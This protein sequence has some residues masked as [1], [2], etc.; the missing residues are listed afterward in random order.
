MEKKTKTLC[1]RD[2]ILIVEIVEEK[3]CIYFFVRNKTRDDFVSERSL[4]TPFLSPQSRT[5]KDFG[6]ITIGSS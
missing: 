2:D 6:V 5:V 1:R 4:D 3:N